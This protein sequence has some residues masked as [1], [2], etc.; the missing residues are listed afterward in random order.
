MELIEEITNATDNK[1]HAIGVFI[2]LKKAFDT[3]DHGILIKKLKHCWVRGVASDWV[4][5]YLSNRKQ[6]VKID[7]CSSE[8]LSVICGVLQGSILGPTLFIL[9]INDICNVSNLVKFILFA[10]DTNVFC[11]GDNQLE[12]ECIRARNSWYFGSKC[13][14]VLSFATGIFMWQQTFATAINLWYH[15]C[16]MFVMHLQSS[17]QPKTTVA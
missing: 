10:D 13:Y 12:L 7:G 9:Y 4:K 3:V 11:A 2:D 17:T 14:H 5:S 16:V 15:V 8:L 6:F 1:K